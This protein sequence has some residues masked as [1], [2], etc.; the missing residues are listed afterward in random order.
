M[1]TGK[2]KFA[3]DKELQLIIQLL[4]FRFD[5]TPASKIR[6][7][8][9][10]RDQDIDWNE[11]FRLV[12]FH[13]VHNHIYDTAILPGETAAKFKKLHSAALRRNLAVSAELGRIDKL[14]RQN[15]IK[16][17]VLKG[18]PLSVLLYGDSAKRNSRDLDIL[19]DDNDLEKIIE[20]F[21]GNYICLTGLNIPL[22]HMK[23][24]CDHL[25]YRNATTRVTVEVHWK[26]VSYAH[27]APGF[28]EAARQNTMPFKMSG[29]SL[30]ILS[31]NYNLLYF[32][33]HGARHSWFRL[34]WLRD[35]AEFCRRDEFVPEEIFKL[36]EKYRISAVLV[37]SLLLCG[38][39]FSVPRIQ[40]PAFPPAGDGRT[41]KLLQSYLEQINR[42]KTSDYGA[43]YIDR[44]KLKARLIKG[45]LLLQDSY[46]YRLEV[47][48]SHFVS[49]GDIEMLPLPEKLFFL[50]YPLHSLL[51]SVRWYNMRNKNR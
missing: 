37:S 5:E 7:T 15:Q 43:P 49:S 36:G 38:K 27:F 17:T 33:M 47:L 25:V 29:T 23:R 12:N 1:E 28:N 9:W 21:A 24:Y 13:K 22:K 26:L 20:L 40:E 31:F 45:E 18:Q 2:I 44:I 11:F 41:G 3:A 34:F 6:I 48:N 46:R 10:V 32:I 16:F 4:R 14:F 30:N 35:L 39:F 19:V 42:G 8:D 50:Y 51:S